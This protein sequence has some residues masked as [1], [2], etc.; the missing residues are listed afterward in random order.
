M[1]ENAPSQP[2]PLFSRRLQWLLGCALAFSL[3]FVL[4]APALDNNFINLDD[5]EYVTANPHVQAG[6]NVASVR[7]AFTN[8][9]MA[10]WQPVSWI[11]HA[12]D[13]Q[14][15]GLN[16][17][18]HHL[19]NILLHSANSVLVFALLF[20]ATGA[21]GRSLVVALLFAVHPTNV[22]NVAWIAERKTLLCSLFTFTTFLVWGWYALRPNWT[23]YL[24]VTFAFV[25]AL[26][27]KPMAVSVP[28]LL[29]CLD[30]WPLQR[31][32][33]LAAG[34]FPQRTATFLLL[35][36]L[37][38]LAISAVL[39][40]VA[41]HAQQHRAAIR[42]AA[43]ST[44]MAHAVWSYTAYLLKLAWPHDLSIIYPYPA[45]PDP[46]WQVV[47]ALA[48]LIAFTI[49][50]F[51]WR[52]QPYL[53]AGWLFFALGMLPV[54]GIVQIGHHSLADRFLY[55]PA[56]GIFVIVAWGLHALAERLRLDMRSEILLGAAAIVAYASLTF[57]YLPYWKNSATLFARAERLS[58]A[59][60]L[61]IE[62][63]LGQG[64]TELGRL[65]EAIPH[66]Q[67][68]M[69]LAPDQPLPHYDLG[70]SMLR[71]G[72]AGG[73]A[74]QFEAALQL[75]PESRLRTLCLHNLGS[76]Q[77]IL[78]QPDRAEASFTAALA[79]DPGSERSYAGRGQARF[80][81]REYAGAQEDL[82]HA[83][84]LAQDPLAYF[85]MGKTLTAE[86]EPQLA[87]QAF[88]SALRLVPNWKEVQSELDALTHASP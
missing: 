20:L 77:I 8:V 50:F 23:R 59:P 2:R 35:E 30:Y 84:S 43:L 53:A 28:V 12:L 6:V 3:A 78:G 24:L 76:A 16:P 11:S 21:F 1:P 47:L 15:Y 74:S 34:R 75:A 49:I 18:G 60:D 9:D 67:L 41:V 57:A 36:K 61:L 29:L 31:W 51:R 46:L 56:L 27:S 32:N 86:H 58:P 79:L 44:R 4:Y 13:C 83:L 55:T 42:N 63:N 39:S 45:H 25:L 68:A 73:A 33:R 54:V 70:N 10:I 37:P 88:R 64:L 65:S 19:T 82:Q 48:A 66:Y 14:L 17:V 80:L 52:S 81:L 62:T 7:W 87:E 40:Q 85:W 5:D 26:L 22:E 69:S 38:L 72:D 71:M